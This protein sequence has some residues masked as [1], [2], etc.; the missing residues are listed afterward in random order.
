MPYGVT[1]TI[2]PTPYS[3]RYE[4]NS[5]TSGTP[6]YTW[7]ITVTPSQ[8]LDY[9]FVTNAQFSSAQITRLDLDDFSDHALVKSRFYIP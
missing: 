7:D 8:K 9:A 1:T 3:G 6:L 5:F 2:S 4:S